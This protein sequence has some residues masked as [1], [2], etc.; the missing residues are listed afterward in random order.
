[1]I[2]WLRRWWGEG[3]KDFYNKED[4]SF[5]DI[6]ALIDNEVEESIN[7]DFKEARSLDKSDGKRKEIAKDV[8]A[9]A[10]S[11]GGIII[12]GIVEQDH[13]AKSISFINGNEFTKE[14][15]EQVINSSIQRRI[16]DLKIFVIRHNNDVSKTIYLIKIPRSIDTPHLSKD[17]RFYKRFNFESVAMEEYEI[18]QLYGRKI[19]SELFLD[20]WSIYETKSEEKDEK[21]FVCEIQIFN[22]GDVSENSY[23][24]NVIFENFGRDIRL[25]WDRNK[26]N[27]DYTIFGG[28]RVKISAFG[29]MPIF[30]NETINV[31]RFNLYIKN[32]KILD[33]LSLIKIK[34]YLF[35]SNGDDIMETN[36]EDVLERIRAEK[37]KEELNPSKEHIP[38]LNK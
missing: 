22:A 20:Q 32:N 37:I 1:M 23:K 15:L 2:G 34:I 21:K 36:L 16:S 14:W 7:L 29:T 9:F 26:N 3:M 8:S 33:I 4:Y 18:R 13:K 6:Q 30:P 24:I 31:M 19:K 38:K 27:Y 12:Y 28:K 25:T 35:Y 17:K 10:N 11:D 5:S